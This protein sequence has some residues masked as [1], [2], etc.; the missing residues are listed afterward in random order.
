MWKNALPVLGDCYT[1][2]EFVKDDS[3]QSL[4]ADAETIRS[5]MAEMN[6]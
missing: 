4:A 3:A 1:L 5:W 2:I 6:V